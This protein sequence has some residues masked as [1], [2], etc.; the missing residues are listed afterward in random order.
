MG[1]LMRF[2]DNQDCTNWSE[3]DKEKVLHVALPIGNGNVLMASD[4]LESMGQKLTFGNNFQIAINP[5]SKEEADRLFNGLS[6]GG[7]IETPMQDM[8]WGAYYGAFA[9]KFGIQWMINYDKN[10][11]NN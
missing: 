1:G 6:A 9:D 3:S 10:R 11:Q 7:K 5:D 8:F 4:A 2:K